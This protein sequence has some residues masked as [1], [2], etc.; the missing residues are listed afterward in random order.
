MKT[1]SKIMAD[2]RLFSDLIHYKVGQNAEDLNKL[3]IR[4]G[5]S[6]ILVNGWRIVGNLHNPKLLQ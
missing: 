6:C 5:H 2:M 3:N 4:Y 1:I